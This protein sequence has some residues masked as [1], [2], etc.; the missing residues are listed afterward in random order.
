MPGDIPDSRGWNEETH[1]S[2][3]VRVKDAAKNFHAQDNPEGGNFLG[4]M[5]RMPETQS[6]W[7]G[8]QNLWAMRG[9]KEREGSAL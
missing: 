2:Q 9:K 5:A 1:V 4:R 7:R 6:K 3:S 8:I